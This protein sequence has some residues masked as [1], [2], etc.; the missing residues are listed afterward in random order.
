MRAVSAKKILLS[1][2]VTGR[3]ESFE[4]STNINELYKTELLPLLDKDDKREARLSIQYDVKLINEKLFKEEMVGTGMTDYITIGKY[5]AHR[6]KL[7]GGKL[8]MRSHNNNQI[9]N[10]KS[11]NITKKYP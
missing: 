5:K 9:H 4:R 7:M 6:T 8:Q 2:F 10:L 11:Q 3:P 1:E